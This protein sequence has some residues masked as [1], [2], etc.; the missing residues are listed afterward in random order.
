MTC[1]R[2]SSRPI[3]RIKSIG[4]LVLALKAHKISV[5]A[6]DLDLEKISLKATILS[7]VYGRIGGDWDPKK[8]VRALRLRFSNAATVGD[9]DEHPEDLAK[10]TDCIGELILA[11]GGRE[12]T[13]PDKTFSTPSDTCH[14]GPVL[15]QAC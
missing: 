9:Y 10:E 12:S 3:V 1:G 5:A 15:C 7:E 14:R 2:S 13:N 4:R 6:S 8:L 11:L